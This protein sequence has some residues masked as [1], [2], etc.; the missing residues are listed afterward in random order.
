MKIDITYLKR[1]V[2][3]L[4]SLTSEAEQIQSEN[5][6]KANPSPNEYLVTISKAAGICLGI[7]SEASALVGDIQKIVGQSFNKPKEENLTSLLDFL[8]PPSKASQKN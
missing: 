4:E 6:I 3:E 1:L 7:T 8:K 2:T 5:D